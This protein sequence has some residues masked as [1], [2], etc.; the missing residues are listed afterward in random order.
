MR[1]FSSRQIAHALERLGC[2]PRYKATRASKN[3][4][5]HQVYRRVVTLPDGSTRTLS[6]PILLGQKEMD[7][8]TLG[9]VLKLLAISEDEFEAA[10]R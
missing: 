8:F 10:V 9:H 5:S 4:G 2:Q 3:K 7:R 1:L 6:A